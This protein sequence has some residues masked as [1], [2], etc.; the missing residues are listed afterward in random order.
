MGN[1]KGASRP[2]RPA[3]TGQR[4]EE[5][6]REEDAQGNHWVHLGEGLGTRAPGGGDTSRRAVGGIGQ[7]NFKLATGCMRSTTMS[8][9]AYSPDY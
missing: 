3:R 5:L 4:V 6:A 7:L 9:R 2:R 1:A 8:N